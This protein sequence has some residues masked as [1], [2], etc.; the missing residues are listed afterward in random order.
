MHRWCPEGDHSVRVEVVTVHG[1][2]NA[3][4]VQDVEDALWIRSR[5]MFGKFGAS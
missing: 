3:Q 5:P 2:T 4:Q 1:E